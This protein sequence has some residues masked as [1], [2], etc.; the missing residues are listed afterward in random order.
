MRKKQQVEKRKQTTL[1]QKRNHFYLYFLI[2]L[3]LDLLAFLSIKRLAILEIYFKMIFHC[4]P[5]NL[6]ITIPLLFL[7]LFL[8]LR[9]SRGLR[10]FVVIYFLLTAPLL[11]WLSWE[12]HGFAQAKRG[13]DLK[14]EVDQ[15]VEV[16]MD[17]YVLKDSPINRL[18][19]LGGKRVAAALPLDQDNVLA[20]LA[21]INQAYET[22]SFPSNARVIEALIDKT[23]DVAIINRSHLGVLLEAKPQFLSECRR[24]DIEFPEPS[25][26]DQQGLGHSETSETTIV[27]MSSAGKLEADRPDAATSASALKLKTGLNLFIGLRSDPSR[28]ALQAEAAA[29]LMLLHRPEARHSILLSVPSNFCVEDGQEGIEGEDLWRFLPLAGRKSQMAALSKISHLELDDYLILDE[30]SLIELVDALGG[31]EVNNPVAYEN[32]DFQFPVGNLHLDHDRSLAYIGLDSA[33]QP[34]S[35]TPSSTEVFDLALG[36]RQQALLE[37]C[38]AKLYDYKSLMRLKTCL[39]IL[40]RGAE[41]NLSFESLTRFLFDCYQANRD[42]RLEVLRLSGKKIT[43]FSSEQI[44]DQKLEAIAYSDETK[45]MISEAIW[46]IE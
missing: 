2:L 33:S 40:S 3:V 21:K 37:G 35:D 1:I 20:S 4:H 25:T 29:Q 34:N 39:S 19:D 22:V 23:C 38:I 42:Q 12:S 41:S 8:I 17:L 18:E 45:S 16:N 30:S 27:E 13:L 28:A 14:S 44:P 10:T 32:H 31:V 46:G 5:F 7:I 36:Q 26:D 43:D 11:T 9:R 24:L 6:L 15:A